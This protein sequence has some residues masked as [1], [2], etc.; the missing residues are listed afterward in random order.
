M[1]IENEQGQAWYMTVVRK[2]RSVLKWMNGMPGDRCCICG[3]E[4]ATIRGRKKEN[5][6]GLF[7]V[8]HNKDADTCMV[9]VYK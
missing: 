9:E 7:C 6:E 4:G 2:D 5:H 3:V 1:A 8:V